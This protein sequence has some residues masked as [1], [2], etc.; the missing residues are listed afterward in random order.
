ML[1]TREEAEKLLKETEACNPGPWGDHSRI[2]QFDTTEEEIQQIRDGLRSVCY[3]DY[4]R[5]IQL[6]DALAGANSILNV[7]ERMEDVKRRYG[8]YPQTKWDSNLAL[9]AY[10]EKRQTRAFMWWSERIPSHCNMQNTWRQLWKT[11]LFP[12]C[13]PLR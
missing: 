5:L 9:K 3:D 12:H 1:P 13:I 11:C 10:F 6:C 4:D 8:S 7:E 2:G